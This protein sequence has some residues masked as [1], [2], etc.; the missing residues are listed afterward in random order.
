MTDTI[1]A[2]HGINV[3]LGSQQEHLEEGLQALARPSVV[4]ARAMDSLNIADQ[5]SQRPGLALG[6]F[7]SYAQLA[8]STVLW[9]AGRVFKQFSSFLCSNLGHSFSF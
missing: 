9:F 7:Y 2:V 3:R 5:A 1:L 4:G 8:L 6:T